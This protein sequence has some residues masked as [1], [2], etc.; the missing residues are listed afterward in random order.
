MTHRDLCPTLTKVNTKFSII[1]LINRN[2]DTIFPPFPKS[3]LI[4]LN[5]VDAVSLRSWR[6]QTAANI[7]PQPVRMR[8]GRHVAAG[9]HD[10]RKKK[11]DAASSCQESAGSENGFKL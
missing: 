11:A 1:S 4:S 5:T 6:A 2:F 3:G 9:A 8:G 10:K 7:T